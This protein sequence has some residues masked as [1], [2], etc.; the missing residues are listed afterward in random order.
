MPCSTRE[1]ILVRIVR[2]IAIF[3]LTIFRLGMMLRFMI[4]ALRRFVQD[5]DLILRGGIERKSENLLL[6]IV[7]SH[8]DGAGILS[9]IGGDEGGTLAQ[10]NGAVASSCLLFPDFAQR[11][12]IEFPLQDVDWDE[13]AWDEFKACAMKLW[14]LEIQDIG[15]GLPERSIILF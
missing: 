3:Q 10:W 5:V 1:V 14:T 7:V 13:D 6:A 2:A 11:R 12:R 4:F 8:N 15:E 9:E